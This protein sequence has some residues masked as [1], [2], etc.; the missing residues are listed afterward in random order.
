MRYGL[1]K[2]IPEKNPIVVGVSFGGMLATEM[3]KRSKYKSYH[4]LP[5]IK[6]PMNFPDYLRAGK[7]FPVYKWI[8]AK[9]MKRSAHA[10]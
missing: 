10:Y 2:Q 7:Y 8:P 1:R 3:A 5:V 6:Q 9:L 4:H